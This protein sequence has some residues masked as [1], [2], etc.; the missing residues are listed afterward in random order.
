MIVFYFL[1]VILGFI[2]VGLTDWFGL[3][4]RT[5]DPLRDDEFSIRRRARNND[6]TAGLVSVGILF[7]PVTLPMGVVMWFGYQIM[8]GAIHIG[9]LLRHKINSRSDDY[10]A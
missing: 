3:K 1:G 6:E 4:D 9:T 8:R 10:D 7:W 5:I 2:L